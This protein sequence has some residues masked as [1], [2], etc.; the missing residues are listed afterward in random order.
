[1]K[2]FTKMKIAIVGLGQI[3]GSLAKAFTK[4]RI[5]SEI[6]GVD[7]NLITIEKAKRLKIVNRVANDLK[8]AIPQADLVILAVPVRQIIKILPKVTASM[9]RETILCEVGSTKGE[10]FKMIK[11]LPQKINY[12]GLHPMA[13]TEKEG[14]DGAEE[15][16]FVNKTF[17]VF[18]SKNSKNSS[19]K[20]ILDLIKQ[21]KAKPLI[22][23]INAHDQIMAQV[24]HL[25][26]LFSISLVNLATSSKFKDSFKVLGGSFRDATRVAE[27]SPEMMLD[28]LTTNRKNIIR[29]INSTS[30][31]LSLYK[32]FLQK[33][34]EDRLLAKIL[35]AKKVRSR[36]KFL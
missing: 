10:I 7:K 8:K 9:K 12:I 13:G 22:M 3:G 35:K 2:D 20:I 6:I 34:D 1:M 25:P 17:M 21:L 16:L 19:V 27:S 5:Y 4:E 14:I 15:N 11:K 24:S 31:E 26:Y 23:N 18:P 29:Q 28:I 33:G 32:S 36:L 30:K